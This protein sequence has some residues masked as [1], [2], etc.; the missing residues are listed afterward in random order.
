MPFHFTCHLLSLHL[1]GHWVS[2][3]ESRPGTSLAEINKTL[4]KRLQGLK[5]QKWFMLVQVG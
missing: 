4:R 5:V 2:S 3:A 1:T